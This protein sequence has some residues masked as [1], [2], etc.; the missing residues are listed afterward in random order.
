MTVY[1]TARPAVPAEANGEGWELVEGYE[2]DYIFCLFLLSL[3][4]VCQSLQI[5]A[6]FFCE[7][8]L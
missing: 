3:D 5:K 2:R 1:N 4:I 6:S 8:S 7:T